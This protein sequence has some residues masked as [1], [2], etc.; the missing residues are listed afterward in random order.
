MH[1][2]PEPV[3]WKHRDMPKLRPPPVKKRGPGRPEAVRRK[4]VTVGAQFHRSTTCKYSI[5]HQFG[6]NS[7]N[8]SGP[9]GQLVMR[10]KTLRKFRN[11]KGKRSRGRPPKESNAS[12]KK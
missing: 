11:I 5:C 6:H 8:H 4:D 7:R 3:F 10:S 12:N 9:R 1:P 2:I